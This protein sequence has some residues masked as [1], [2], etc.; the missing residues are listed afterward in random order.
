LD[1][2]QDFTPPEYQKEVT[3]V[4]VSL[5]ENA[6]SIHSNY[7]STGLFDKVEFAQ[8]ISLSENYDRSFLQFGW[9]NKR[10]NRQKY[11]LTSAQIIAR[12]A[13]Y[14]EKGQN[15]F[16]WA[17]HGSDPFYMRLETMEGILKAAPTTFKAF[18]F[19][20]LTHTDD[21]MRYVVENHLVPLA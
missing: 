15:F 20:E 16:V 7:E 9:A 4:P 19:A 13:D 1:R 12:A 10:D 6:A 18:V 2:I 17:G 14:E 3:P 21:A 8:Y 5:G 11:N